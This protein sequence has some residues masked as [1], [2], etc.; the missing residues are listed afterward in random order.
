[1]VKCPHILK[2]VLRHIS[3]AGPTKKERNS[4]CHLHPITHL[5]LIYKSRLEV[6]QGW[7]R[8]GIHWKLLTKEGVLITAHSPQP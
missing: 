7:V 8:D 2:R 6:N 5:N 4:I 1:M 3:F